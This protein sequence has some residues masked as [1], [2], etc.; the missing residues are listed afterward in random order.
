MLA[1]ALDLLL[2]GKP[3]AGIVRPGAAEAYVEGV[4]EPHAGLLDDPDLAELRE[5]PADAGEI[6]LAGGSARTAHAGVCAGALRIGGG[7]RALGSRLISFYGQHEHRKLTIAWPSSTCSTAS[8]AERCELSDGWRLA[9]R[10]VCGSSGALRSFTARGRAR[11]G[12]GPAPFEIDESRRPGPTRRGGRPAG[13]ARAPPARRRSARRRGGAAEAI[14]P[15]TGD[16]ASALLGEAEGLAAPL[17][18][19]DP[20]LVVLATGCG[21][22]IEADDLAP[23]LRRYGRAAGRRPGGLEQPRSARAYDRLERKHGGSV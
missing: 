1:H 13:G 7:P 4:F 10:G 21:L 18:D 11:A 9:P 12:P 22:R 20:D 15:E 8:A 19:A 23:E 3:R 16:G 17:G 2:G 5:R 6:V 14:A